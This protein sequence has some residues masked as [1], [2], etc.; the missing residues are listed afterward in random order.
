MKRCGNCLES[1]KYGEKSVYC[2]LY[3]I[4]IRKDH[5]C[6]Y[7]KGE[8]RPTEEGRRENTGGTDEKGFP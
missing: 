3:G 4:V 2:V 6:R 7:H 1:R 8:I 5:S